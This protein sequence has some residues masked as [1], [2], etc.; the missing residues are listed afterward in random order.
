MIEKIIILQLANYLGDY[1]LQ[2]SFLAN[3][4]GKYDYLLFV[5][6]FIWASVV[7][8]P[9]MYYNDFTYGKFIFLLVGHFFVDRIKA[10]SKSKNDPLGMMLWVDQ[11]AHFLQIVFVISI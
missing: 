9:L 3:M 2:G 6:S 11:I 1:P 5:H 4:K 10:R 8:L 7:S